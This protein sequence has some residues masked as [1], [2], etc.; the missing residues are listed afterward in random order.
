V[1]VAHAVGLRGFYLRGDAGEPGDIV[2]ALAGTAVKDN[3]E[4]LKKLRR[5]LEQRI[6]K[7]S[8]A[9]WRAFYEARHRLPSA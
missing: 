6:A 8:G 3:A 9:A 5:Y 2:E 1:S 4:D 7:R